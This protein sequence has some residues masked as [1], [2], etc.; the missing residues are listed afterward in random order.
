MRL[1]HKGFV[2]WDVAVSL[3]VQGTI[4]MV[5]MLEGDF[6]NGLHGDMDF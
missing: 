4:T 1:P 2:M 6:F 5:M 3:E